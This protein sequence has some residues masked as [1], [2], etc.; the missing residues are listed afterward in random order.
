MTTYSAAYMPV[1]CDAVLC[2][3]VM[4]RHQGPDPLYA[5]QRRGALAVALAAKAA[6]AAATAAQEAATADLTAAPVATAAA[7]AEALGSGD[8]GTAGIG[9]FDSAPKTRKGHG[10]GFHAKCTH[11][12]AAQRMHNVSNITTCYAMPMAMHAC[13]FKPV[14]PP[15][16][17]AFGVQS[18]MKQTHTLPTARSFSIG[19]GQR[20]ACKYIHFHTNTH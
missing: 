17:V 12:G 19:R 1:P 6:A 2:T 4:F 14:I 11:A 15:T 3:H 9:I 5:G 7:T 8:G 18:G 20:N 10:L 16:Q 13:E